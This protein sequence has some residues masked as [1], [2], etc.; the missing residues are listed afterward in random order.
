[1]GQQRPWRRRSEQ[2]NKLSILSM[3]EIPDPRLLHPISSSS[4]QL[5]N[6]TNQTTNSDR[7]K[8]MFDKVKKIQKESNETKQNLA[9]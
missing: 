2:A 7:V 1:V 6:S 5:I 4:L 8:Q 9:R 3:M